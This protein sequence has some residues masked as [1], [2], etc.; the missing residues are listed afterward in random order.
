MGELAG[1]AF[2]VVGGG[3]GIGRATAL[4]LAREGASVLV[5]DSG[6]DAS[7]EG[8]DD[9]VARQTADDIQRSGGHALAMSLDATDKDTAKQ[10]VDTALEA[11]GALHGGFY[12]AG[13]S[14]DRPLARLADDDFDAV[15]GVHVHGAFRFTRELA[16]SFA[17]RRER[18]SIV[19][20]AA[21]SGLFGPSGQVAQAAAS[22]AI[23]AL[24]RSAASDRK[25][26]V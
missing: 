3:R 12:A 25:S 2:I 24:T 19:L 22:G 18:G 9:D 13:F 20:T 8:H 21:P 11:F 7:G 5:N 23:A 1:K 26:V 6:C 17:D 15:L 4:L 10:L 14:R 16:K